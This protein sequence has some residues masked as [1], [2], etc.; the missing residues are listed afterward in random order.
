MQII[1][2]RPQGLQTISDSLSH[3][4]Q[5]A[6]DEEQAKRQYLAALM[7][8]QPFD[9]RVALMQA[10]PNASRGLT[11]PQSATART[12]EEEFKDLLARQNMSVQQGFTPD[13]FQSDI[14]ATTNLTGLNP[15]AD[16]TQTTAARRYLSPQDFATAQGVSAKVIPDANKVYDNTGPIGM[17]DIELKRQQ[18]RHAGAQADYVAGPQTVDTQ[19]ATRVKGADVTL[20]GAQTDSAQAQARERNALTAKIGT[21]TRSQQLQNNFMNSLSG[22]AGSAAGGSGYGSGYGASS[23]PGGADGADQMVRDLAS[24]DFDPML[25]R[26]WKPEVVALLETKVKQLDPAFS[27]SDYPTQVAA[28][29]NFTSGKNGDALKTIRQLIDHVGELKIAGDALNNSNF[30]PSVTNRATNMVANQF[31]PDF[32]KRLATYNRAADAVANETE[33][34]LRGSSISGQAEREKMR[35]SLS[36]YLSPAA[37]QGAIEMTVKLMQDRLAE[38]DA[39]YQTG[40]GRGRDFTVLSP[41]NVAILANVLKVDPSTVDFAFSNSSTSATSAPGASTTSGGGSNSASKTVTRTELKRMGATEQ[42]ATAAGYK[43]TD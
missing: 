17:A 40:V 12:P 43:V 37:R 8:G 24:R 30:L 25:L 16:Y 32:Q 1:D 29:K 11:I 5:R 6:A 19:A 3:L 34:M 21:E 2:P 23:A 27:M 33:T 38:A 14:I 36:Q 13:R 7:Q 18:G 39:Q 35:E 42:E 41:R 4:Q 10:N 28:K 22:G 20:K 31:S 15:N 9:R 26:R